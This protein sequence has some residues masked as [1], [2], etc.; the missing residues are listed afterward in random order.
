MSE[1]GANNVVEVTGKRG[2]GSVFELTH[3]S[4][5]RYLDDRQIKGVRYA[6][7]WRAGN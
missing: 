4:E 2:Y 7:K 3:Y 1:V 6:G 5:L